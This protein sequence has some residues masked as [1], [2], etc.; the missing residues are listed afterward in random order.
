MLTTAADLLRHLE[1]LVRQE[2]EQQREH[3]ERQW[4]LP[5]G[6]RVRRGYALE[7]LAYSGMNE[8]TGNLVFM[9]TSNNARFREGDVLF[10][11]KSHPQL[12]PYLEV[13]LEVDDEQRLELSLGGGNLVRI[14]DEPEG[15]IADEGYMDLSGYY[16][17]ALAEVADRHVGRERILPLLLGEISPQ[18]D[19]SAYER[20]WTLASAAGLNESQAE[21]LGQAYA[22]DLT[23]LIQGPPGTGK[24]L[25][26]AHLVKLLAEEGE[27]VLVTALTHRAIHNALDKIARVAPDLPVCKIGPG[28]RADGLAVENFEDFTQSQFEKI[29][30]GYIIGATPF[31]TRTQRLSEVEFDTIVFDEAS[32]ITLPLAIMGMLAGKRYIFIGDE[33]QLPPVVAHQQTDL[34]LAR[35]SIFGA[36]VGH[37][38]KTMLTDTYRM[39]DVLTAW[40]SRTFYDNRLRPAPGI[41]S[42]RLQLAPVDDLWQPILDPD[43]PAVFVDL[44]SSNTTV[45]S[46]READVIVDLVMALLRAGMDPLEI[47]VIAPYR[48]QG[49]E[50]RN[51][52]RRGIKDRNLRRALVVDT[53]ERMQGQEREVILFS[54][55][56]ASPSF[57]ADLAGFFFQ[58]QRL[59]VTITRPRTKLII[60]GSS[61]VLNA[62]PDDPEQQASIALF[63]DLLQECTLRP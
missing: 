56:T 58:E 12:E 19:L 8:H 35:T 25:V 14:W 48:A 2:A 28:A 23:H 53:V 55:T 34:P 43:H 42:R 27:R 52:L 36:L 4:S 31:A 32:Q 18:L 22:T 62:Q 61:L 45:R 40:P 15:W 59:N 24:T 26:L 29:P 60:V 49:R 17:D 7:G 57:A 46:Y 39:N 33:R 11:H 54:M 13:T 47:G 21:A 20:G 10:L 30:D 3:L 44:V 63:R 41:G 6:E 51:R 50:I 1:D 37:S 9:C 38:Y 5:L 16:L